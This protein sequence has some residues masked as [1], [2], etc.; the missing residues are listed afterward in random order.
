VRIVHVYK[1]YAPVVGG[2][3]NHIRALAE[4]Q[5][6]AGH[7]VAV[8]ITH[9]AQRTRRAREHGV[10]VVRAGRL[11]TI[12]STP[13]SPA[14]A[15]ALRAEV[16]DVTHLHAPYPVGEAAWLA[17]G[18]PPM[19]ISYHSDVVRQRRLAALWAPAQRAV[20]RRADAI[21]AGSPRLAETS[22]FL[23]PYRGAVHVVPYG[24]DAKRFA[25]DAA[26]QRAARARWRPDGA[27]PDAVLAFV[28]RLRY[29]KGLDTA[30]EALPRLPGV[31]LL[32]VGTGPMGAAWRALA[33]SRG[34]QDR[35]RWL[36][37]VDDAD[38]PAVLAAADAY[39]LPASARSEAFGIAM[40]E[41]MAAGLPVIS[42]ELGTGT[43]WV[44]EDGVTGVVVA[45][46]DPAALAEGV[47]SVL[48][49]PA[50]RAALGRAA[51]A[52]ARSEFDVAVM[53][54]RIMDIYHAA[55]ARQ[56][57]EAR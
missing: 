20:L 50:R 3:E 1:D 35:I 30:I 52:R 8:L 32:V 33:S 47:S 21:I 29:Y 13:I 17:F 41:G 22:P 27:G 37:D 12:A 11:A 54:R 38:L 49:D 40:V 51:A 15:L 39:V 25:L 31:H 9:P 23:A 28:G 16:V 53:G 43:S 4:G 6:A 45:P 18:R 48:G 56:R 46:R 14:L 10:R 19:V 2:I 7:D 5:A 24:I 44:N 42:T 34:V 36:G 26:A 57:P 55:L